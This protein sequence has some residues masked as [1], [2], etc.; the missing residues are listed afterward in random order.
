MVGKGVPHVDAASKR[1]MDLTPTRHDAVLGVTK[2]LAQ[3]LRRDATI[4]M[5]EHSIV[6]R[7][8]T[9]RDLQASLRGMKGWENMDLTVENLPSAEAR[10]IQEMGL[11][12]V[13]MNAMSGFGTFPRWQGEALYMP[14]GLAKALTKMHELEEKGDTGV[15]DKVTQVFRYS[16]LGLSPRYTAHI[17]FGGTFMLAVRSTPYMP[18]YILKAAKMLKEGHL[19]ERLYGA[20]TEEGFVRMQGTV[21]QAA[22]EAHAW[23]SGE[24]LSLL[25]KQEHIEKVQGVLLH[26]ASP[27]HWLKAGADLNFRFTRYVRRLNNA[28]AYLDYMSKA[29][30]QTHY[31]DEVTG[32]VMKMT[33]ERAMYEGV[34]HVQQVF[35]DLR[36]M[37]PMERSIA[38]NIMPFYGWTRHI[39]K[40]VLTMPV[41]HPWR[42]MILALVAYENSAD[43]PKALPER[44]QFLFFMG[45]PDSQGNVTAFDTR[46]MDPLRDVANY[47]SLGGWIQGLNPIFQIPAA[48]AYGENATYGSTSL[49]PNLS[50]N[51]FYGIE[52]AGDQGNLS[53]GLSQIV[54]QLGAVQPMW[55]AL[56]QASKVRELKTDPNAFYKNVFES[57]NIPFAQPQRINLNQIKA[58]DEIARYEVARQAATNA[59]DSGNFGL[60]Q[61]YSSVPNPVN[62]DYEISVPELQALY[63][64]ALQEYPGAPPSATVL[65]PPTPLGY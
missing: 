24:Q 34:K 40:Y 23:A 64:Q 22:L 27:L 9:G 12:K 25:A 52:T 60:L 47:A 51:Q 59:F 8:I 33:K 21:M 56:T 14:A 31:V 63:N 46:F 38:K 48:M 65:P 1:I 42:A 39:I 54:P 18:F 44:I 57:L 19:P 45:Q 35:G 7:A 43:V 28:V 62:P 36:S 20:N 6:P 5:W 3:V 11:V 50:Y 37:S 61:G 26:Q 4:D 32:Q 10:K 16:I 29:E 17:L 30:R 2:D 41:D 58:S 15:L 13:D 55:D 49:Y 53:Q